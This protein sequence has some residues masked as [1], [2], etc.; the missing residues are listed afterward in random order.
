MFL[1]AIGRIRDNAAAA[2]SAPEEMELRT[3]SSVTAAGTQT[4][5]S[6]IRPNLVNGDVQPSDQVISV[7]GW[8]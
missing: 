4:H 7:P 6:D 1:Q 5:T 3:I 2:G 8:L